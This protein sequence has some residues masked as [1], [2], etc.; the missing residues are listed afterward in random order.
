MENIKLRVNSYNFLDITN[1]ALWR[2][3]SSRRLVRL[4]GQ[5]TRPIPKRKQ[6]TKYCALSHVR[7]EI[8]I[9]KPCV[10]AGHGSTHLRHGGFCNPQRLYSSLYNW[11]CHVYPWLETG[12]G[13]VIG[14]INH[15]EVVITTKYNTV[16][17]FHT[18]HH[19]TLIHSVYFH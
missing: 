11:Y 7:N 9:L 2:H 13:L 17:D 16:T 15:L 1:Y 6:N 3:E 8:R 5:E 12:F 10:R 19:S 18:T 4:L 14:F